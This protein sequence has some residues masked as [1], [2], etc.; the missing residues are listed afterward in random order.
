MRAII[1]I[2]ERCVSE[3]DRFYLHERQN[4]HA[5]DARHPPFQGIPMNAQDILAT[6]G[7]TPDPGGAP[8]ASLGAGAMSDP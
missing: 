7:N 8:L 3:P 5:V 6:L 4:H 1:P 2:P